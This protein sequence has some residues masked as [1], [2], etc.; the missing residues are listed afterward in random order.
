MQYIDTRGNCEP[1]SAAKAICLGIAPGGGLFVPEY[2]P[3]YMPD[4]KDLAAKSYQKLAEEILGLYLSDYDSAEISCLVKAAY[5]SGKFDPG[6]APC[7]S[8]GERELLELWHGPTA[9]FKDMALQLMPYLLT[10]AMQKTAQIEGG[11]QKEVIILVATSGDTGK[12]ALEGFKDVSGVKII[13][14][15]PLDGV[16]RV[17]ELQMLTTD[18][19]NT[20]VVGVHG[21][22]DDC[23]TAVKEVF[24]NKEL[25][26]RLEQKNMVFSSANS[27]NLGRLLPQVIYYYYGY[28]QILA[29][30]RIR[31]GEEIDVV[32]PTG[33]FGNI[34]AAYYARE[35]GLPIARLICASNENNILTDVIKN[36]VYDC[37]RP[38]YKTN[39]P[40]MDILISSNFERFLFE[41]CGRD[42][43]AV[44]SAFSSLRENGYFNTPEA[45]LKY[46]SEFMLGDYA[47]EEECS[48]TIANVFAKDSYLLDPHTAVAV[49]VADRNA[50]NGTR[51]Q[52]IAS[53]ANPYKFP[54]AV[55][56]ALGVP[57]VG[58]EPTALTDLLAQKTALAVHPA[59]AGVEKKEIRHRRQ[60]D[61]EQIGQAVGEILGI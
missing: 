35:M 20:F 47:G 54:A 60:V 1:V 46:W 58:M 34:L 36:G 11:G 17:Q 41:A 44:N 14:F 21:N 13:V 4:A 33:N 30:G 7:V 2:F 5:Y 51:R 43:E 31:A 22:F 6:I 19:N 61:R 27:I 25:K 9:A 15:Y 59:L 8:V 57:S 29:K 56:S 53:T 52:M 42:A 3:Q 39:S 23:Q 55:L 50:Q 48:Q 12:A 18:G 45:A 32:V 10:G 40:S 49:A 26:E 16:S 38:F 37:R 28:G 24:S